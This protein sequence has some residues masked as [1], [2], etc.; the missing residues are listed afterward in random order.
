MEITLD[1]LCR[2]YEGVPLIKYMQNKYR[3]QNWD[4]LGSR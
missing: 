3:K 1:S 2:E 4:H